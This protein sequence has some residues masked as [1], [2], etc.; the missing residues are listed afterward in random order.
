VLNEDWRPLLCHV[1]K[2]VDAP[3]VEMA[4][5]ISN[6]SFQESEPQGFRPISLNWTQENTS[7]FFEKFNRECRTQI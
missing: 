7:I 1:S 4:M 5:D 2:E 3:S 6:I